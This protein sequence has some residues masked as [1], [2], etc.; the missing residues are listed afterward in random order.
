[1]ES[2]GLN[3]ALPPFLNGRRQFTTTEV[4]QSKYVTKVRWVVEAVNSRIKQFKY[5]ANT[6]PNSA[7]PHLEHDVSIVC[8]I[9]N[10]YRPPIKTSNAEDVAIAEKMILLRSRKNNFEKFLQRNNLKKSSSKWHAIDHIDIIDEFPILSEGTFQLKR[11]RSYAEE[12]ASTT[13]LTGSVNYTIHRCQEFPDIIRV[14]TQSAHVS[15]AQ[16]HPIIR[17]TREEILD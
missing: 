1:M 17:F 4:N 7:L 11:A 10:R 13:D 2:L 6:I 16:Y 3:V 15:R 9:I 8:A 5:L 14:P 12:N